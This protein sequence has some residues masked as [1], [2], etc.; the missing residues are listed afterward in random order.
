MKAKTIRLMQRGGLRRAASCSG[1][2]PTGTARGIRAPGLRARGSGGAPGSRRE[3]AAAAAFSTGGSRRR[4]AAARRR[5]E[6][7]RR[8]ALREPRRERR[9]VSELAEELRPFTLSLARHLVGKKARRLARASARRAPRARRARPPARG[10]RRPGRGP[11][12][13]ADRARQLRR[14]IEHRH[15]H[16]LRRVLRRDLEATHVRREKEQRLARGAAA[17]TAAMPC[18]SRTSA[19]TRSWGRSQIAGV[20]A[21]SCPACAIAARR[22][23]ASP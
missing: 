2:S 7:R 17:S 12:A 10:A 16:A 4:A 21:S 20:S 14:A 13:S 15:R 9:R 5:Q 19:A 23:R 18:T 6:S 3:R 11:R 1:C 22:T 8:R